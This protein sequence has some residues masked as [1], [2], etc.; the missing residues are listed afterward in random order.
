M[1][2]DSRHDGK[3]RNGVIRFDLGSN[4]TAPGQKAETVS[5][6]IHKEPEGDGVSASVH[7]AE[8]V[9][10]LC[11][12][13]LGSGSSG[14]CA[15]LGTRDEGV[16]IDAGV[17]YDLL[18]PKLES[19]GV[20]PEMLKGI[21]LTHDH[22]DHIRAVYKILRLHKHMRFYCTPRLLHA[23]MRHHSVSSKLKDYHVSIWKEI[24]FQLAGFTITAFETS[25]DAVDNMGFMLTRDGQNFV[26]ATD[27]GRVTPRARHYMAQANYLMI[28]SNYDLAMLHNGRYPAYLKARI[29][30]DKGHLDNTLAAETVADIYGKH[31]KWVL[32]CHLSNDNNTP[33]IALTTMERALK[34]CGATVGD[35]S[36]DV[37]QRDRDIQLVALP[38]YDAS[39]WFTLTEP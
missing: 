38:R 9:S 6:G 1:S 28:E 11:F 32:L 31:L 2:K 22:T 23:L 30:G 10:P 19:N 17:R 7:G 39:P 27:M 15:Y 37:D 24:P 33:E 18:M 21:I 26:V 34:S 4:E 25:H 35:G 16:L 3:E 8:V 14:N 13:S 36:Y 20:K 12:M 5:S 29:Y